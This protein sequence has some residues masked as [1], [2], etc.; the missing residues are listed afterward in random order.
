MEKIGNW[1]F[2]WR[3][4]L[5]FII[6]ALIIFS[7]RYFKYVDSSEKMD[8]FWE[9]IC[10]L[11]SF[12]GFGIRVYTVGHAPDG[13]S[14]RNTD[15]QV[16]DTLNTT[17]I[18]SVVRNPLYLGNFI[19][20]LGILLFVNLWGLTLLSVVIFFIYYKFIILAEEAFL[21]R[22]FEEKYNAWVKNT[23]SF[24]PKITGWKKPSQPFSLRKV[25]RKEFN[26]FFAIILGFTLIEIVGD[27]VVTGKL[28]LATGW[29]VIFGTGCLVF[30]VILFL[31]KKT[32]I[33]FH[34]KI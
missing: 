5:P 26:G 18:Y 8:D 23:P 29:R 14:G 13:T 11:I 19:I 32:D 31:K 2:K 33:L 12:L 15:K 9:V 1:F 25:L 20:W 34:K 22:K 30:L 16:A 10:F 27:V 3:G 24:I 4:H 6:F 28:E 17:G 7:L 21:R